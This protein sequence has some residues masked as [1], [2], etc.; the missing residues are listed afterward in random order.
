MDSTP[1]RSR[2][3]THSAGPRSRPVQRMVVLRRRSAGRSAWRPG[4]ARR[5][6]RA[7]RWYPCVAADPTQPA[8]RVLRCHHCGQQSGGSS[9]GLGTGSSLLG[10]GG[11]T[12]KLHVARHVAARRCQNRSSAVGHIDCG[13]EV[14]SPIQQPSARSRP[15]GSRF[16]VPP[17]HAAPPVNALRGPL[18]RRSSW[19]PSA[20]R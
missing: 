19:K 17:R 20:G 4:A 2:N 14:T 7:N 18:S 8:R 10:H 13:R 12:A 6:P 9:C 1:R 3:R 5:A 16:L 15:P 11:S